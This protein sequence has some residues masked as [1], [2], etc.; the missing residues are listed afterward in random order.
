[1][2]CAALLKSGGAD[3]LN[4]QG[5]ILTAN[6]VQ[7]AGFKIVSQP[8]GT[9]GL[10]NLTPDSI[11]PD[12]PWSNVKVRMAAEYALDKESMA[13][14]FG[15]GYT[16]PAYQICAP[17]S[18]GNDPSL[19]PRKYDPAKAKQLLAEAGYPN[20]FKTTIIAAPFG[21]NQDQIVAVQAFFKAVGI[22]A[23]LQFPAAAQAQNYINGLLPVNSLLVNPYMLSANPNR[24]FS[25]YF[26]DPVT[27]NKSVKRPDGWAAL[28][29]A[30]LATPTLD[31]ALA[32]KCSDALYNDCTFIPFGWSM[33]PFALANN[34]QDSGIGTRSSLTYWEPQTVYFSK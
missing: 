32:K 12:S 6:D 15:M 14:T 3:I 29:N 8:A 16:V 25:M 30:T 23:D 4:C 34:V 18:Q 5:S 7:A 20:G 2:T 33:A 26:N 24:V 27:S 1:M 21:L 19:T 10:G 9:G 17:S 11:D 22:Q 13:K 28:L 31:P